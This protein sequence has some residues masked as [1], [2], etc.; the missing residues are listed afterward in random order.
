MIKKITDIFK[1]KNRTF[2]FEFFPPKTPQGVEN[3]YK[4][5]EELSELG[6]DFVSVTYGAGGS[7]RGTTMD[8]CLEI[9]KRFDLTV[10][11]H[12]TCVGHSQT[13]LKA[14]L[15]R[16][17][18]NN[19]R[20][21]LALRGDPPKGAEKWKPAPDGFEFCY[22]LND[23]IC[24][25]YKDFFSIGVAGFPEGHIHCPDKETDTKYLKIK[26]EHGGEFVITQLFFDNAI[27]SEY[28]ERL[29]NTG[30]NVRIIP[31]IL[32]ITNYEGLLKFCN[33]CGATITREV[34]DIFKPLNGDDEAISKA[35][36]EFAVKQCRDLLGRGAPG[37][38][39]FTLNK[40]EP[41]REIWKRLGL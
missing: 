33:I 6:P 2:S 25:N 31:G 40:V 34:H 8:I 10:M 17:K 9:Q 32:P 3:L 11:H 28:L 29:R 21:V 1:E 4:T 27:Y 7:T 30:I 37:L 23:F 13:E 39:F 36:I 5:V 35:G 24:D 12:L 20:N 19:I 41:A 16:M 22:Q 38:H 15:D 18:A 14:I 26:I